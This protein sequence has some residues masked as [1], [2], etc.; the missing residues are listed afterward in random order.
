VTGKRMFSASSRE[1]YPAVG[2]WVAVTE[3]D[4]EQA[5]IEGII[6]RR[7]VL[8]RKE[9]GGP[10]VQVI[11]ANIDVAF[12]VQAIGRDFS[13]NR[14]ERYAAMISVGGATPGVVL[15]KADL[16]S[17]PEA[18]TLMAEIRRR[19]PDVDIVMTS[20]VRDDGLDALRALLREGK[21]YCF[22]G[23]SGVGKSSIINQ[24]LGVELIR[25]QEIGQK[26]GRGTHATTSRTLFVLANGA[27]VIDNPGMREFGLDSGEGVDVV[28]SRVVELAQTCQFS[29]CTHAHENGCAVRAAIDAGTLDEAQYESYAKLKRESEF[30][31]MSGVERR[32]KDRA[33]GKYIKKVKEGVE[34]FK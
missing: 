20:T 9:A 13:V 19:L 26:T 30:Q 4:D 12:I 29:D 2:D 23:S 14:L 33:F 27:M 11:A 8:R 32:R 15:N 24:L 5:V 34:K 17:G 16:A 28:F 6:P 25:V 22:V 1:D 10:E 3:L 7:T 21:T 18:D 31:D